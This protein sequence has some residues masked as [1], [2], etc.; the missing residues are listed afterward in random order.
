[1]LF[2]TASSSTIQPWALNAASNVSTA[3]MLNVWVNF[4]WTRSTVTGINTFYRDG[5][6]IGTYT[7]SAGT[8]IASGGYFIIGQEADA[9]GGG[10]DVN[11]NLDGDF[12]RLDI[13]NRV[14]SPLE[15]KQNFNAL[16]GR[17]GV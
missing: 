4:A 8:P 1:M 3:I 7:G 11:Q 5:Q 15:I 9:P 6:Q 13:Y 2:F 17:F 12:A 14:L 10:F 16:R